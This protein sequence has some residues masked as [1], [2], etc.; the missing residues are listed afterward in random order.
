MTPR[1]QGWKRR[2]RVYIRCAGLRRLELPHT[3]THIRDREKD[4]RREGR[5]PLNRAL[6]KTRAR[7]AGEEGGGHADSPN[8]PGEKGGPRPA[9]LSRQRRRPSL[10]AHEHRTQQR[11]RTIA[12]VSTRQHASTEKVSCPSCVVNDQ[13]AS[14]LVDLFAQLSTACITNTETLIRRGVRVNVRLRV[15]ECESVYLCLL[16]YV[17]VCLCLCES[18]TV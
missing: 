1:G 18:M 15:C 5:R 8:S 10:A 11:C 9:S 14:Q 16:F 7:M 3:Q 6:E 17:S 2:V 4:I 13:Q 12:R